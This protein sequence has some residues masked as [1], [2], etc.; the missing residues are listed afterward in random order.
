MQIIGSVK[1]TACWEDNLPQYNTTVFIRCVWGDINGVDFLSMAETRSVCGELGLKRTSFAINPHHLYPDQPRTKEP[2]GLLA[3]KLALRWPSGKG[4]GGFLTLSPIK[5]VLLECRGQWGPTIAV[6]K[7]RN[8]Y[9]I[10]CLYPDRKIKW[11]NIHFFYQIVLKL[12]LWEAVSIL[13]EASSGKYNQALFDW[14][15]GLYNRCNFMEVC[16]HNQMLRALMIFFFLE[17]FS[18]VIRQK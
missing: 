12:A 15:V 10:H 2:A 8:V 18:K 7:S 14:R 9:V 5:H 3:A 17:S 11:C 6:G 1:W 13:D 4:I 16:S